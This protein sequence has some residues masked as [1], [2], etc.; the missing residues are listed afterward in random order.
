MAAAL[1]HPALS[2]SLAALVRMAASRLLISSGDSL[3]R[4][5]LMVSL[6]R[7]PVKRNGGL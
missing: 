1:P 3:G 2:N 5:S 6:L 4:S 7:F